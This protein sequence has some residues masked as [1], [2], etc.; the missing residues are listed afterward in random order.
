[1]QKRSIKSY[2][3]LPLPLVVATV[4]GAL[5]WVVSVKVFDASQFWHYAAVP[6]GTVLT[7]VLALTAAALAYS[8]VMAQVA[9]LADQ[10]KLERIKHESEQENE[11]IRRLSAKFESALISV[12]SENHV[13]VLGGGEHFLFRV[14]R[15]GYS[16]STQR[17]FRSAEH[18]QYLN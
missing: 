9:R 17:Y 12:S 7:G 16:V 6:Y 2:W 18:Y 10:L 4:L 13:R 14:E 8:G 15:L 3:W 1:M 11:A 5:V